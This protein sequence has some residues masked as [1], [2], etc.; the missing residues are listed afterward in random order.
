MDGQ[1]TKSAISGLSENPMATM[2]LHNVLFHM[3]S[4]NEMELSSEAAVLYFR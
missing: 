4:R 2:S 1:L 3:L